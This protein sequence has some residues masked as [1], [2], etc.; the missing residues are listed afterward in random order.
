[1]A[2]CCPV[3]SVC[4]IMDNTCVQFYAVFYRVYYYVSLI[5]PQYIL[6]L[7]YNMLMCVGIDMYNIHTS[8][9]LYS[10]I[11]HS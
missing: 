1:M 8:S 6:I 9:D 4:L 10:Y 3:Y 2:H 7:S 11:L 5:Q